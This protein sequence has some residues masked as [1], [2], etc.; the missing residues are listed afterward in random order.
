MNVFLTHFNNFA[1]LFKSAFFSFLWVVSGSVL[2]HSGHEHH[3]KQGASLNFG[4]GIQ[5][6]TA[7]N[8]WPAARLPGV[9]EA[10]SEREN[11]QG[12]SI[13]YLELGVSYRF[14]DQLLAV[15]NTAKHGVNM[16][17]ETEALYFEYTD[18]E[19]GTLLQV[20]TR[21]GRQQV[22]VGLLNQQE[23]HDWRL[24]IAPI[25]MRAVL[26][27]SWRSDG[28]TVHFK[29]HSGWYLGAGIWSNSF[30]P[31]GDIDN[32]ALN[33]YTINAG[34]QQQESGTKIQYEVGYANLDVT[35][36][37][38]STIGAGRHTHTLPSC[39]AV[40]ENRVCFVGDVDLI[41]VGAKWQKQKL[42]VQGELFYK[43]EEGILDS[44]FG[45]PG[46]HSEYLGSWL[47]LGW[48]ISPDWNAITRVQ[49]N[50]VNH[51]IKGANAQLIAEQAKINVSE[52]SL[53]AVG[54][55]VNYT[56]WRDH[57]ISAEAH[58]ESMGDYDN[59]VLLLRYHLSF[60]LI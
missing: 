3:T 32:S 52:S 50:R 9:L 24:G 48:Q 28:V 18:L 57:F 8:P 5:S 56:T 46:Y 41:H 22:N 13:S 6:V 21:L 44:V 29:S 7:Q 45:M 37:A 49:Y 47:D 43:K 39:S 12:V 1:I 16:A 23:S 20:D 42:W 10:G 2:A 40:D 11:E 31:G 35:G 26:N 17:P 30:F 51:Q 55:G 15:Y 4:L 54:L 34:W 58:Y 19:L 38:L 27:D 33:T 59:R 14:S 53:T 25:A 36:R 60:S